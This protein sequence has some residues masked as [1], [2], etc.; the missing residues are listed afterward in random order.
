MKIKI[1]EEVPAEAVNVEGAVDVK[2]RLLIHEAEQAPNF[3]MRQFTVAPGGQTPRHTH[4]WE[5]EVYVLSGSGTIV[6]AEGDVS[7]S[8]GQ[9]VYVAPNDDHQFRNTG[10]EDLKFLCLIPKPQ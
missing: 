7:L 8:A 9:A 6:T 2:I 3:Y 4:A 5:H 1:A 10:D